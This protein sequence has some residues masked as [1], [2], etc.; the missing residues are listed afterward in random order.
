MAIKR[1]NSA[2]SV[3]VNGVPVVYSAGQLIEDTDPVF[4]THRAYFE[5]VETVARPRKATVHKAEQATAEPGENRS[6]TPPTAV[7]EPSDDGTAKKSQDEDERPAQDDDA[8]GDRPRTTRRTG[9]S[10]AKR[11]RSTK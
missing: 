8:T 6:L 9:T 7:P 1:C 11:G 4:K 5:D 2:F 3:W 10:T